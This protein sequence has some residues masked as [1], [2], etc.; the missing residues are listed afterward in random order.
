MGL[1][2]RGEYPCT[3]FF[4]KLQLLFFLMH[5]A[6]FAFLFVFRGGGG[7]GSFGCLVG[8]SELKTSGT[9]ENNNGRF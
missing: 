3:A 7:V 8:G 2:F 4:E 5:D 6:S 1:K 9:G